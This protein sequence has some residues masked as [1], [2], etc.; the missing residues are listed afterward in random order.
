MATSSGLILHA[1]LSDHGPVIALQAMQVRLGQWPSFT[2]MEHRASHARAV[3]MDQLSVI[4]LKTNFWS[5]FE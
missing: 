3:Y 4:I 5:S 1:D 2:G